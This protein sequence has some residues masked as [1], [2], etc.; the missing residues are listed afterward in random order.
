MLTPVHIERYW[1]IK[2][3][4]YKRGGF[5]LDDAVAFCEEVEQKMSKLNNKE[6]FIVQ[7]FAAGYKAKEISKLANV[8]LRTIVRDIGELRKNDEIFLP[9]VTVRI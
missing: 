7:C 4:P 2:N 5:K 6:Q 1:A 9:R 8:S 3:N